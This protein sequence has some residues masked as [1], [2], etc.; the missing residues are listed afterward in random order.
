MQG[1][2]AF[3]YFFV[4][5]SCRNCKSSRLVKVTAA[6]EAAPPRPARDSYCKR[7]PLHGKISSAVSCFSSTGRHTGPHPSCK[8]KM[9]KSDP[10]D[11]YYQHR[12]SQ[13]HLPTRRKHNSTPC[14]VSKSLA[15]NY[16][17]KHRNYQECKTASLG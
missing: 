4:F 7:I 16:T 17:N 9:H 8:G 15:L 3:I 12:I 13:N 1:P 2:Q 6:T 5:S 10:P 11:I 14:S